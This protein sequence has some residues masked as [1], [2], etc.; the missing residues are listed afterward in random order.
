MPNK[1]KKI[2]AGVFGGLATVGGGSV[3]ADN[4][5]NPYTD[6]GTTLE[7]SQVSTVTQAGVIKEIVSKNEPKIK[8][9]KWN[10]EV[11]MGVT[12]MGMNQKAK[13]S[14][15]F[16]SK[17]VEWSDGGQKMETVPVA[18]QPGIE[19]GG[20]EINV[21][22]GS[23]PVSNVFKFQLENWQNLDFFY[24]PPLTAEEIKE[25]AQRPENVIGSYAVYYKNHH[26]H[27]MGETNYAT[28]KAYHIFR[29]LVTDAKGNTVW[30][31]LAYTNGVLSV[32][33]P[34]DFLSNASYPV[35]ADPTFGYTTT[36]ASQILV[37]TSIAV[38]SAQNKTASV[39]ATVNSISFYGGYFSS[40]INV[41]GFTVLDSSQ[42]ILT[43]GVTPGTSVNVIYTSAQWWTASYITN[44][45]VSS[46]IDYAPY[47][48][49]DGNS[50]VNYD[51]GSGVQ[52]Y[53]DDTNSYAT[54]INPTDKVNQTDKYSIYATYTAGSATTPNSPRIN[55]Q[56]QINVRSTL[57]IQ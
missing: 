22:L 14:R 18:P 29:P 56:S 31:G 9:E 43:N 2:I 7:I 13:G 38:G 42:V 49:P 11:G 55:V 19:D 39:N 8:L 27:V 44:P 50:V 45:S 21:I 40:T 10:G 1:H 33:V 53:V 35:V 47:F 37:G 6:R 4:M 5:I 32:T 30:A 3:V 51:S 36:G 12:Y 25:G 52:S 48:I 46:G 17:K 24:Q 23:K 57:L 26:D 20:M 34:Q 15:P 28:G 41:K 54:P 16:L